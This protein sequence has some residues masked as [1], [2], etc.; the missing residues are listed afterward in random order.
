MDTCYRLNVCA[1]RIHLVNPNPYA[2]VLGGGAFERWLGYEGG[3]LMNGTS[4]LIKDAQRAPLPSFCHVRVKQQLA[5]CNPGEC[6]H[7]N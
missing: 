6:P 7:Q 1:T 4:A 3:G 5:I 2:M